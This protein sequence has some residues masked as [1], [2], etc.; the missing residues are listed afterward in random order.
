MERDQIRE[1][2]NRERNCNM[3]GNTAYSYGGR[4]CDESDASRQLCCQLSAREAVKCKRGAR[5]ENLKLG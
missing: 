2:L 3:V 4:L 5:R 1:G